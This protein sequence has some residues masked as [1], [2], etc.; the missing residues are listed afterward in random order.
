[1]EGHLGTLKLSYCLALTL[2]IPLLGLLS[3]STSSEHLYPVSYPWHSPLSKI[4]PGSAT[5]GVSAYRH[6]LYS[7]HMLFLWPS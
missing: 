4:C 3:A 7:L 1:M 5:K 2:A 6:L